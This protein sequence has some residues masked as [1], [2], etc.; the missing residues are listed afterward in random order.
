[1]TGLRVG[2]R[3]ARIFWGGRVRERAVSDNRTAARPSLQAHFRTQKTPQKPLFERTLRLKEFSST[4]RSTS[5]DE[6]ASTLVDGQRRKPVTFDCF[7]S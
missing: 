3:P 2:A 1:M 4:F 7:A 6:D 5:R